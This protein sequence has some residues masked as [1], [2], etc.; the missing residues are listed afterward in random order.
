M[1]KVV[2]LPVPPAFPTSIVGMAF[3]ECL[4]QAGGMWKTHSGGFL[5]LNFPAEGDVDWD[6]ELKQVLEMFEGERKSDREA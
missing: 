2:R 3:R 6:V 5:T 4:L 1:T